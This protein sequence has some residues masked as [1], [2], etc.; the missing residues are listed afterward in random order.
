MPDQA[1]SA[2]NESMAAA[3]DAALE[4]LRA[5]TPFDR[6]ALLA[7]YPE[8]GSAI[9][10]LEGLLPPPPSLAPP[11]AIGRYRIERELGAGGFGVVYLAFDPDVQ[12]Q[13]AIKVLHPGRLGQ[14]EAVSR[15]T[16]EARAIGR[17]SHPGIVR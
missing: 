10:L 7:K 12:R 1:T 5:G 6:E 16:R 8:L 9:P 13:V 3:L 17:L 2:F 11:E 15:F 14:A 4:A